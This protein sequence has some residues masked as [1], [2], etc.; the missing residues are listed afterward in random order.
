[1]ADG[2]LF[3]SWRRLAR[4]DPGLV[5]LRSSLVM[6]LSV[7]AS[8]GATLAL[9][10]AEGLGVDVVIRSVV[11]ALSLARTQQGMDFKHRL[12]GFVAMPIL[13]VAAAKLGV[14]MASH[15]DIGDGMFVLAVS[16]TIWIRRFGSAAGGFATMATLPLISILILQGSPVTAS[17][18]DQ[19]W[20]AGVVALIAAFWVFTLQ[21][22]A[23]VAGLGPRTPAPATSRPAG[24]PQPPRRGTRTRLSV[25]T[26][27]TVQVGVAVG[28]AFTAGRL[29]WTSHWAWTVLTAFIVCSGARSRG[30][31]MHKG[32]LR[33]LGAGVGTILG[34]LIA[35]TFAPF[36]HTSVVVIFALIA[37]ATWLRPLSY[38]Y[39][40]AGVT[41]V[42]SLLY[43]YFGA[44]ATSLLHTRLEAILLGALIG[45]A[46]SWMILPI[47]STDIL[48][49]R[50]TTVVT[51]LSDLLK[52]G[53]RDPTTLARQQARFDH[54]V[55]QLEQI[56]APFEAH[57]RLTRHRRAAPENADV[58]AAIRRSVTPVHA[59][60]QCAISDNDVLASPH[61]LRVQSVIVANI[62]ALRRQITGVPGAAYRPLPTTPVDPGGN[63]NAKVIE[64]LTDIDNAVT[65]LA[66]KARERGVG[67]HGS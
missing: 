29:I 67:A 33:I 3:G 20:W 60:I 49:R 32:A 11:F 61:V 45:I 2:D 59:L 47:R 30:D 16:G 55:H 4:V 39:W 54:S 57:R 15:A 22:A 37:V 41:A 17:A 5:N 62:G 12:I 14:L 6:M 46:S 7:L 50:L 64:I 66:R 21:V 27:M 44:S 52:P 53:P 43:G 34:T 25:S 13:A 58:I 28:V 35:S 10:H 38:A 63:R 1:M 51:T 8:Y 40:A 48:R 31:V 19:S 42:L 26:R 9:E 56:A 65:E 36:D 18:P 24:R 23:G